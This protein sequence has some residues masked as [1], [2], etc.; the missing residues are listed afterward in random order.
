MGLTLEELAVR[1]VADTGDFIR[2]V[3]SATDKAGRRLSKFAENTRKTLRTAFKVAGVAAVA[4]FT[5]VV[6]TAG[7]FDAAM[8]QSLAI[9][10]DVSEA[11]R[12]DMA[13]AARE[14]AKTTTFS[15]SQA[16]EAY[17]YLASAGL[18]AKASIEALPVVAR[19]AQAGMF[20]MATAT[21]LLTDAQSALGLTIRDDAIANMENMIALSDILVKANT[22][23][24]ATVEQFA[25]AL[26]NKA[27]ASMRQLNM[28]TEE[29]IAIL[30]AFADQGIKDVEAGEKLFIV[31]RDLQS[32][33]LRN[34]EEWEKLNVAAF[35]SEGA[36]RPVADI[37]ED[38]TGLL[39]N[40][41]DEQKRAT[42]MMLGFQDR[43][44]A[45]IMTLLG[46]SDAIRQYE[47]NLR[48][49]A[50]T[51]EDIATKQL[52]TFNAQL[53]LLWHAIQDVAIEVGTEM[54]PKLKEFVEDVA[55]PWV[56]TE[57][58]RHVE[59]LGQKLR[60]AWPNIER[61]IQGLAKFMEGLARFGGWVIANEARMTAALIAIG[62]ALWW[63]MPQVGLAA[64]IIG[65]AAAL[66]ILAGEMEGRA[67]TLAI[68]DPFP[69]SE[70]R[71]QAHLAYLDAARIR[72]QQLGEEYTST[73]KEI[74]RAIVLYEDALERA[75]LAGGEFWGTKEGVGAFTGEGAADVWDVMLKGARR[76]RRELERGGGEPPPFEDPEETTETIDELTEAFLRLAQAALAVGDITERT[77]VRTFDLARAAAD[78]LGWSGEDLDKIFRSS[79]RS[80]GDFM[81]QLASAQALDLLRQR[82]QYAI[83]ALDELRA[84]FDEL[85]FRPSREE[86]QLQERLARM[87]LQRAQAI[88][89]GASEE[90]LAVIDRQI[91]QLENILDVR[92]AEE[93]VI[94]AQLDLR[95]KSLKSDAERISAARDL[96]TKM[97]EMSDAAI[98]IIDLYRNQREAMEDLID[99]L[100]RWR[101]ILLTGP[102]ATEAASYH[103]GGIVPGPMGQERFALVRGGEEILPA[104]A[105]GVNI[106]IPVQI[107]AVDWP[108]I[109]RRLHVE[110]DQA[111]HD[112]KN[113]SYRQGHPLSSTIG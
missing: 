64:S 88:L 108:T 62:A 48:L 78:R 8:T 84:S 94:R 44:V 110:L 96:V 95:D 2:S 57:L 91:E 101:N 23:S 29:G 3:D 89:R 39:S 52:N 1:I 28:D 31:F 63:A 70:A 58:P 10:G 60:D 87:R 34:R 5:G 53:K 40:M 37:V 38:L 15:A 47:A 72:F 107:A 90:E 98:P 43:S 111:L 18:D 16:A 67:W 65:I 106:S 46:S 13:G 42:L 85:F 56:A 92:R 4:A 82:A 9:M 83:D 26:T 49:A 97:H 32:A 61:A 41:S 79:G 12:K 99:E 14:V 66:G 22:L 93:D 113:S 27:A 54:L 103:G 71:I 55:K 104:G 33:Q 45:A 69:W 59:D 24:N 6:K 36:M 51:T 17:F 74:D 35:D 105:A 68:E 109:R 73:V 80:F 30:A 76:Y 21:D 50:G 75:R 77:L 11:M 100:I 7:D 86:A 81:R 102:L 19:F 112:A 20:D 25:R